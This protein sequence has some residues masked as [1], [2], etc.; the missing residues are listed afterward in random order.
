MKFEVSL[1]P[2][3]VEADDLEDLKIVEQYY[4][5]EALKFNFIKEVEDDSI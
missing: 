5:L 2:I 4:E 1:M 3:I